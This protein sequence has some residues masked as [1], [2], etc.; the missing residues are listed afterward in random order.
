[1]DHRLDQCGGLGEQ[2]MYLLQEPE[3]M[4][5]KVALVATNSLLSSQLIVG[6]ISVLHEVTN[7]V[8]FA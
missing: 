4:S 8:F 1:M 3:L 7:C 5:L 2:S 6:V